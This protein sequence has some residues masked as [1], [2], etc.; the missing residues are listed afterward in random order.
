MHRHVLLAFGFLTRIPVPVPGERRDDDLARSTWAFPLV[1]LAIG[2]AVAGVLVI[3]QDRPFIAVWAAF[4]LWV[5]VTGG[6]HLDGLADVIDG[7]GAAHRNP[8]RFYQVAKDPHI[9]GL[10]AVAIGVQLISTVLLLLAID[11]QHYWAVLLVPAWA[12]WSVV[13]TA[14]LVPALGS[15]MAAA[16]GR[17]HVV[18]AAVWAVILG[19]ASGWLAPTA[20][21]GL[22][23]G[24]VL[25]LWWHRT[26]GGA[27]G[28]CYGA[29]IEM[30]ETVLLLAIA[31]A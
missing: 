14:A 3:A 5:A 15:G 7:M 18:A 9:G 28:D 31:L 22:A 20:L 11:P 16:V 13:V 8:E 26:L 2:A 4:A 1:G 19:C 23:C 25:A 12:R 29:T 21:V 27:N 24:P 10:G 6:L 30:S 17:K